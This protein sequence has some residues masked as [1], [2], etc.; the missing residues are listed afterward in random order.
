MLN[1]FDWLR[2]RVRDAFVDGVA[3]GMDAIE[4]ANGT[5]LPPAVM[6]RLQ[7]RLALPPPSTDPES[8]EP[9]KRGAK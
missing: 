6:D 8:P 5:P 4:A 9:R 7:R 1:P 2:T 3:D